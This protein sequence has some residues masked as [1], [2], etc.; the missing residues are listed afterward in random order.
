VLE[1][2]RLCQQDFPLSR[3]C[4]SEEVASTVQ[5]PNLPADT[6]AFVRPVPGGTS[7]RQVR[8][9][10]TNL[11]YTLN[12]PYDSASGVTAISQSLI[13]EMTCH[14]WRLGSSQHLGLTVDSSGRFHVTDCAP[15]PIA[16]CALVQ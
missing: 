7:A 2:T 13:E 8:D 1:F 12:V 11:I 6:E 5:L 16:C 4:T 15:R 9:D 10:E 3:I 14:G